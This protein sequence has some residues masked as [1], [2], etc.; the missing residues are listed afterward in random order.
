MRRIPAS[1]VLVV[2]LAPLVV[3]AGTVRA[4]PAG[5]SEPTCSAPRVVERPLPTNPPDDEAGD[6]GDTRTVGLASSSADMSDRGNG[7]FR[8]CLEGRQTVKG[9]AGCDWT[10]DRSAVLSLSTGRFRAFG[11]NL[12][13]YLEA[14]TS[15]GDPTDPHRLG[16]S[17]SDGSYSTDDGSIGVAA[18]AAGDW[19]V[20]FVAPWDSTGDRAALRGDL[21]IRCGEPPALEPDRSLGHATFSTS[22][23]PERQFET[24]VVCDWATWDGEWTVVRVDSATTRAKVA[25]DRY[26]RLAIDLSEGVSPAVWAQVVQTAAFGPKVEGVIDWRY[27]FPLW[28]TEDL[29]SGTLRAHRLTDAE[30]FFGDLPTPSDAPSMELLATWQCAGAPDEVSA[31]IGWERPHGQPGLVTL[32]V[33]GS[34]PAEQVLAASCQVSGPDEDG[35][36]EVRSIAAA[37]PYQAWDAL[38]VARWDGFVAIYLRGPDGSFAG[39]LVSGPLADD[40][41]WEGDGQGHLNVPPLA[42]TR[43]VLSPDEGVP[44][45]LRLDM[46]WQCRPGLGALG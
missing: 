16:I 27:S 36:V 42:L 46:A 13:L 30:T 37:F 38:L 8:L 23:E 1:L 9:E 22:D 10:E 44:E 18:N 6:V 43:S 5:A 45:T 15:V 35:I 25:D 32:D 7:S 24:T 41:V 19:V 29:T 40:P 26:I 34:S 3:P 11:R 12:S 2:L 14:A 17:W 28:T 39:S 21:A 31:R 33:S 4:A 20:S